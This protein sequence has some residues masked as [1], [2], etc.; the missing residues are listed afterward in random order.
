MITHMSDKF[1]IC[2]TPDKLLTSWAVYILYD[3][4]TSAPLY[5]GFCPLDEVFRIPDA[6]RRTAL[7]GDVIITLQITDV[8]TTRGAA[9]HKSSRRSMDLGTPP[10]NRV[11]TSGVQCIETGDIWDNAAQVVEAHMLS[12]SALSNHLAGKPGHK[13]VKGRTYRRV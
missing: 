2:T 11:T 10:L 7:P 8:C 6:R 9:L 1:S 12:A 4:D 3:G 5:V 13:T